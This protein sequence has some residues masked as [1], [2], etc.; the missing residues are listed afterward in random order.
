[1]SAM[2]IATRRLGQTD[3]EVTPVGLGAWQFSRGKGFA[4][5]FWPVLAQERIDEIVRAALDGGVNWFDTAEI[6]GKGRSEAALGA[7]LAAAGKKS[8]DVIVATK[9]WPMMRRAG[10]IRRTIEDRLRF[11][12][13]FAIDLHQVH[14]PL[15]LSSVEAEMDAMADL[16]EAGKIRAVGVSNYSA[17]QMRRAH[18]ALVRRGLV[19]ASNQVRHSLMY[20]RNEVN[21]VIEAARELGISIIAWSPLEQGLLTGKF[22]KDPALVKSIRFM[23]RKMFDYSLKHLEKSRPLIDGLDEVA[24]RHDVTA[25]Q[26]ALRWLLQFHGDLV[27]VIPGA[28][29]VSHVEQNV[30]AMTF[31]LSPEELSSLDELSRGY[32]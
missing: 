7:A 19:L 27:V 6:Y 32:R 13:G 18:E 24:R 14:Q 3:L 20:R 31:Q 30:G 29:K 23:R 10:S 17:K 25:A 8:G 21:G 16:V 11:L 9:W 12:G 22:H 5:K 1:M 2:E 26:A 15:S 4:S 28:S